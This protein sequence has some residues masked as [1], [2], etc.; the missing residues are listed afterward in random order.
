MHC[1]PQ[2]APCRRSDFPAS[3]FH[4]QSERERERERLIFSSSLK[5]VYSPKKK[6]KTLLM[7]RKSGVLVTHR[8]VTRC[9][10]RKFFQPII[11]PRVGQIFLP[12]VS[13]IRWSYLPPPPRDRNTE[14][15]RWKKDVKCAEGH[16]YQLPEEVF[17][18]LELRQKKRVVLG[19]NQI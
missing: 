13:M 11:S 2:R 18:L 14:V 19:N 12:R 7:N 6:E 17:F 9:H 5:L 15:G 3:T 16:N 10:R 4:L 1:K 8:R